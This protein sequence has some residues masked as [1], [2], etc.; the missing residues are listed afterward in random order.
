MIFITYGTQ[1]HDF[2]YMGELANSISQ[3]YQVVAQIGESTNNITRP[4]TE[5][6]DYTTEFER[7]I[8]DCQILITHGG[9]GSIM[10]GL[11]KNKKVIVI[12]RLAKFGE[13][14]DDHQLE[15]TTKLAKDNY[16]YYMQREEDINQ[17]IK[18]ALNFE[19]DAYESNTLNFVHN[20]EQILLGEK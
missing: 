12:P 19:F 11:N 6:F 16:I 14:V 1:P 5:V 15:V 17:V 20:I 13:H 9:V 4:N 2:K 8:D 7:Y 18:K 3:D 10:G